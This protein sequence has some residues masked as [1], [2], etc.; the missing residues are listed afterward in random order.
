MLNPIEGIE[1]F[2]QFLIKVNFNKVQLV[3]NRKTKDSPPQCTDERLEAALQEK[4]ERKG[5]SLVSNSTCR[6]GAE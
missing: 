5:G 3:L 4:H 6:G 1:G 2:K